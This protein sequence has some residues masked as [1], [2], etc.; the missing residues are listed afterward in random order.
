MF[1]TA[2]PTRPT[3]R[4]L[5]PSTFSPLSA[6]TRCSPH[7][8]HVAPTTTRSAKCPEPGQILAAFFAFLAVVSRFLPVQLGIDRTGRNTTTHPPPVLCSLEALQ[9][10]GLL[11]SITWSTSNKCPS[12]GYS[13]TPWPFYYSSFITLLLQPYKAGGPLPT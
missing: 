8:A 2:Q 9:F 10:G 3:T 1:T 11:G 12:Q 7:V 4:I 13:L 6:T 5:P